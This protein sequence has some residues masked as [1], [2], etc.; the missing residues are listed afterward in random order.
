[1]VGWRPLRALRP[2][3]LSC[4]GSRTVAV[5]GR[6][7][8]QQLPLEGLVGG[9]GK[10]PRL[11]RRYGRAYRHA[12]EGRGVA[13][14]V[15]QRARH[16]GDGGSGCD[17]GEDGVIG[18]HLAHRQPLPQVFTAFGQ[19]RFRAQPIGAAAREGGRWRSAT[20]SGRRTSGWSAGSTSTCLRC[21]GRCRPGLRPVRRHRW[22]TAPLSP[23]ATTA[24]SRRWA[25]TA[26]ARKREVPVAIS[27]ATSAGVVVAAE[28]AGQQGCRRASIDPTRSVPLGASA[29]IDWRASSASVSICSA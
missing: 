13:L 29:R 19:P 20:S 23:R 14:Q 28:R 15:Q 3:G 1:M 24:Q 25:S 8:A 10:S 16:H 5:S 26:S 2:D 9:S 21:T 17:A 18:R 7:G 4:A 11:T 12:L 27:S 6:S 22:R